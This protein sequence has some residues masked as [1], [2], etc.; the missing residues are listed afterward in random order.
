MVLPA[1]TR[2]PVDA[3]APGGIW[4]YWWGVEDGNGGG[5]IYEET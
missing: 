3:S 5:G 1:W 2:S 4:D